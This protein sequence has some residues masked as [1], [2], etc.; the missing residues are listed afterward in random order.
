MLLGR[1]TNLSNQFVIHF[2]QE[3]VLSYFSLLFII[4]RGGQGVCVCGG[5]RGG[6]VGEG[7]GGKGIS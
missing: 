3:V 2:E 4:V 7:W 6:G 1:T 5:G